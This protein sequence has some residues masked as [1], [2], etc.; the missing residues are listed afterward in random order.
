MKRKRPCVFSKHSVHFSLFL[1]PMFLISVKYPCHNGEHCADKFPFEYIAERTFNKA[2]QMMPREN[3]AKSYSIWRY[4]TNS[5]ASVSYECFYREFWK[6]NQNAILHRARRII[7]IWSAFSLSFL[8]QWFCSFSGFYGNCRKAI[9]KVSSEQD[10]YS[11][12][13]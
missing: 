3:C 4:Y 13:F 12:Q 6:G 1:R 5:L 9:E 7:K 2:S 8:K 10:A 11:C